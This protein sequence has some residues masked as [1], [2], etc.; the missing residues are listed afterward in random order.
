MFETINYEVKDSI[1]II[2]VTREK[3]LNAINQHF[4]RH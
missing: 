4:R 1:G 3:A 2:T